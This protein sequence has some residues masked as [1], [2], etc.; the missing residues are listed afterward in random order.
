MISSLNK[1]NKHIIVGVG[2]SAGGLE[3]IQELF[4]HIPSDTG[5]SFVII[6]H[7]SPD[8][9]SL[10]VELL[11]K[12]TAMAI[13]E[14][15][16]NMEVQ[17]SCIYVMPHR[18]VMTIRNG[19]LEL[20]DKVLT[21]APNTAIDV[22][23]ESLAKDAG[24]NAIGI[25][26]S[27]TGSD[28]TKGIGAI[29]AAG[30]KVIVQDPV[31]AKFDGMPNNAINSGN[32]DQILPLDL[33][34]DELLY[35]KEGNGFT[36]PLA[37]DYSDKDQELN[38]I[39]LLIRDTSGVDFTAY[40]K[41]TITRRILR[42]MALLSIPDLGA[43]Y[44]FLKFNTDEIDNLRKEFLIGVTQFFRDKEAFEA[45]NAKVLEPLVESKSFGE[46]I[47][48]WVA[49]C[50]TGEEAYSIAILIY[51]KLMKIKKN[52]DVK[53]F[54]TDIDKN[55][56]ELASRGVFSENIA[57]QVDEYLLNKYFNKEGDHFVINQHIRKLVIFAHHDLIKDPPFS[58]VDLITCRNLLIYLNPVLQK[59][60]MARFHFSLNLG[61][62][63][64]LGSSESPGEFKKNFSDISKKWKI[65]KN[66]ENSKTSN[67]DKIISPAFSHKTL[68]S[69]QVSSTKNALQNHV[70]ELLNE[71]LLE[72]VSYAGL[73]I[74]ENFDLLHALGNFKKYLH[75][76]DKSLSL[77]L[78]KMVPEDLNIAMGTAVRKS[79]KNK[80]KVVIR[81]IRVKQEKQSYIVNISVKP[82]LS[83]N[84]L[85]QKFLLV[86]I[87]EVNHQERLKGGESEWDHF[88]NENQKV[89]DLEAELK[90][91]KEHLQSAIEELETSN[92]ELQSA[93]EEL[94]SANEELQSTNEELQ[95]LNEELHTVNAEHQLKIKELIELNDDLSN[96]FSSTD[97]GQVFID[98]DLTIRKFTPEVTKQINLIESD[99]GRS[100]GHISNNIKYG[101]LIEDIQEVIE[102]GRTIHK[103]VEINSGKWYLMKIFPYIRQDKRTDGVIVSFVDITPLKEMNS[104]VSGVINSSLSGIM[105]FKAVRSKGEIVDFDLIL[106]NKSAEKLLD[107]NFSKLKK[108]TFSKIWPA[109]KKSG[110]LEA[111]INV[112]ESGFTYHSEFLFSKKAWFDVVAVKLDDGFAVTFS[113]ITLRKNSQQQ[114]A[115]AYHDLKKAEENLKKLNNELENRVEERTRALGISEERFRLI[116][117]ATNDVVW[118]WNLKTGVLWWNTG[119]T[120]LFGY[121]LQD[122]ERLINSWQKR[123][124]PSERDNVLKGLNELVENKRTQWS[125]EYKFKKQDGDYAYIMHRSFAITDENEEV[126]RIISSLIDLTSLKK[127]Q[128]DL[129]VTNKNLRKINNDLD[130]FIYTASHD[131]RAPVSNIEG[132]VLTLEEDLKHEDDNVNYVLAL[133][134]ESIEKFKET[135]KDLTDIVKTQKNLEEDVQDVNL[136]ELIQDIE[137]SVRDLILDT[138]AKIEVDVSACGIIKFSKKNL[139]SIFYNL[140]S[141]AIKYR[142]PNRPPY[143]K[144]DGYSEQEYDV[145]SVQDNGLGIDD[146]SKEKVFSMFKRFHDHVEGTGIG[147]YIVKRII[148]NAEGK[149]EVDSVPGEGSVFRMYFKKSIDG[150]GNTKSLSRK[151]L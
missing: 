21:P 14:A 61:G 44:S 76:P 111:F 138:K 37:I 69:Q 60:V 72:E 45:L 85:Q 107:K 39:L 113:D 27:G 42:R 106:S 101:S 147:L 109:Y 150:D 104:F 73:Y 16:D 110:L 20:S 41:P 4:D 43:Y 18:K 33:I 143:I 2:A 136:E 121:K 53:I 127:V 1:I 40:K 116:S 74:D 68:Q 29:Q 30:G 119:F 145:I 89:K 128:D 38:N 120:N 5:I 55:A 84:K 35:Y 94:L 47:K 108:K 19:K 141:N 51:E 46:P 129:I 123:I 34:A 105:A 31:T 50:S 25:I 49:G 22:F 7:L 134:K 95:S 114:L 131:L 87:H 98:K 112:T 124:H 91:T 71:A 36:S 9:K 8:Y 6:Q 75:L 10:M 82:Y 146:A 70:A 130:N 93:N 66:I 125:G 17:P 64:F 137:L 13:Y 58:K 67:F 97:I 23:F 80:E 86:L 135:I 24:K 11:S 118:D 59:K 77:N 79:L 142:H 102:E 83:N 96:Y 139:K 100:I 12:H 26:L 63:L 140:L 132:L 56:V 117:E 3:A 54:A 151:T 32:V 52:L 144:V 90:D 15:V 88:K 149:I 65:Y 148:E 115:T 57:E 92:E 78:L 122:E 81:N 99:I 62:A 28:G 126:I 133:I 48:I 103:E